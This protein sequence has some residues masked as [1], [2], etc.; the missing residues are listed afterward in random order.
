MK[1][2]LAANLF[3]LKAILDSGLRLK[4]KVVLESTI[5]EEAGGSGGTLACFLHGIKAGG[6]I[7][8]EPS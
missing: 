4:G 8:S 5:E 2:G 3:A 6:M 7:I 1:A